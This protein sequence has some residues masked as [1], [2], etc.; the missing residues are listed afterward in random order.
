MLIL[1]LLLP[2]L[3]AAS[4][5]DTLLQVKLQETQVSAS[6]ELKTDMSDAVLL[7]LHDGLK[8]KIVFQFRLYRRMRG[9]WSIFGDRIIATGNVTRLAYLDIF[10]DRYIIETEGESLRQ[11]N[12]QE[13]FMQSFVRCADYSLAEVPKDDLSQYYVLA[14]I[15]LDPVRI[16]AP[17]NIITLF[18]GQTTVTTPWVESEIKPR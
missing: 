6:V 18:F 9:P 5:A 17:L 12:Q 4:P 7:S 8:A 3:A 13:Q 14:R 10:E 11:F 16:V 1:P 2:S 15:R